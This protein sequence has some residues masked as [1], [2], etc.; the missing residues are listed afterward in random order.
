MLHSLVVPETILA[1]SVRIA[2]NCFFHSDEQ[3][4]NTESLYSSNG[5]MNEIYNFSSDYLLTLNLRALKRLS[6]VQAFRDILL[7]CSFHV[8]VLVNV[9]PKCL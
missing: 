1:D 3:L 8:Q 2:S 5:R 9:R 6:L 7:T 4:S